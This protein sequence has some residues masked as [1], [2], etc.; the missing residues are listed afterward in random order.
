VSEPSCPRSSVCHPVAVAHDPRSTHPMVTRHV[1]GV[2]KLVDRLQL[3]TTVAPLTLSL[4]PI[5]VCSMLTD[6]HWCHA[7]EEEY[8][9]L[10]LLSNSTWDLVPRPPGANVVTSKCIFQHKFMVDGSL[11]WYKARWVLQGFTQR[12]RVDYD[13]TSAPSSSLPPSGLC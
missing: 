7:I 6:P 13:E 4:V 5:S 1:V 8:E 2:T 12:L 9:A 3:S 11:D 10:L